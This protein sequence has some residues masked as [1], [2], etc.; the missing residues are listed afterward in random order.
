MSSRSNVNKVILIGNLG[1]DPELRYTAKG[2]AVLNLP[3]ATSRRTKKEDGEWDE[4]TEWHNV[5][6]WGKQ[7]EN[8]TQFLQKGDRVYV[9]GQLQKSSWNDAEGNMRW[10][11]EVYVDE[12]KFLS[13]SKQE[14]EES[15]KNQ[16][17]YTE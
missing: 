15:G 8:C 11:S 14:R 9:E 5:V 6:V 4:R 10:K 13:K 1:V 16:E 12:V 17:E 7:A 3:L 2:T